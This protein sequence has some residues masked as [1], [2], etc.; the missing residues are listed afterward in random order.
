M[1]GGQLEVAPAHVGED[2]RDTREVAVVHL[3]TMVD[4]LVVEAA[5]SIGLATDNAVLV[6]NSDH[7]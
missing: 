3:P 2:F 1:V 4:H 6:S 5:F 7:M